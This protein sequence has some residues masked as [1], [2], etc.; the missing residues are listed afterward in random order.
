MPLTQLIDQLSDRDPLIHGED[1]SSHPGRFGD[2]GEKQHLDLH[3]IGHAY[4]SSP[5]IPAILQ[6]EGECGR[7]AA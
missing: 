1:G 2:S 7:L 5:D 3:H 6:Q 4:Y